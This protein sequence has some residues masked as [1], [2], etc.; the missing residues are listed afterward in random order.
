M[1]IFRLSLHL[2]T[3]IL[4]LCFFPLSNSQTVEIQALLELKQ[5]LNDPLNY[6]RSWN[7]SHSLSQFVGITRDFKSGNVTGISLVKMSLSG[8]ISPSISALRSLRSLKLQ[9]NSISSTLPPE[10]ANCTS[11]QHLNLSSN[12]LSGELPDLSSL[13][14]LEALDLSTNKFSGKFPAWV[15]KLSGL[16]TLCLGENNFDQ[17]EIQPSIGNLKNLSHLYLAQ[18]NLIGEI[19][20]FIFDLTSLGT[21]DLSGNQISGTFPKGVSNL[22]NLWKLELYQNNLTGAIIPELANL[23]KLREFD[24]SHNQMTGKLPPEIGNMNFTLF[25][26]FRNDFWGELPEG[27]GSMKFLQ[28]FSIYENNFSGDFPASFGRF[29][30]LNSFDISENNFSGQFPRFL[31]QNNNL[32][33]LLALDNKFAGEFPDSYSSCKSLQRFR[34]SQNRFTGRVPDGVWGLPLAVVI[35]VADNGFIGGISKDIGISTRLTQLYVQNNKFSLE[36][37]PEIGKLSQLQKVFAYNNSFSGKIPSQIGELNLL[38]SLHLEM[39]SLTGPIPSELAHCS[40][41]VDLD[42]AQNS[43]DGE[44]PGN[45]GLLTSLNSFN[46][47]NN[48]LI[49]SIPDGLQSL[50]LSS[51]DL[52]RNQLSGMIPSELLMI[53]GEEAFS[54]NSGLCTDGD[55]GN[56]LGPD[57][58]ICTLSPG[59]KSKSERRMSLISVITSIMFFL[60]AGIA[61]ISYRTWKLEGSCNKVDIEEGLDS[62]SNFKLEAFHPTELTAEEI[63]NLDEENLL[64]I[65]G[66]GKVYRLD[67]T[68][69]RGSVAVKQL[70]EGKGAKVLVGEI[71]I[72][73]KIRH[74]NIVKLYA[75]VTRGDCSYLVFEYM[76]NGNL[77]EA[78]RKEIKGGKPELDWSKRYNIALG[79]AKGVMYLHHDC[80]PAIVHRDIKSKNILLDEEYEAKI[81]DFGI[82]K[83]AEESSYSCF[84]G[85]Y[86]YMAPG[87]C[88][89]NF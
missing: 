83:V 1:A 76:P 3:A 78:L 66:T 26:I 50:K 21:L 37:P 31:C 47:S 44:I 59:H 23:T 57:I 48:L 8:Q 36:L 29:S 15:G 67:L 53:A 2:F 69:S 14:S 87:K 71:G 24:I 64:G 62:N 25:Q 34:I 86:G 68:K 19:P 16:V 13:H 12:K 11:L 65:G 52:S 70:W 33:Y 61:F 51:L 35:D 7:E 49:G 82:A 80:L 88:T 45:I 77:Y 79:A 20:S 89:T 27:F 60:L 28:Y 74:R 6:L 58:G 75:L 63:C 56:K 73:A 43:L 32:Q 46:L 10:L 81:A 55:S 54:G 30:A 72:L 4:L 40:S 18:C 84:A 22:H 42:L 85:T 38:A 9:E 41:L 17:G 5:S 39:N